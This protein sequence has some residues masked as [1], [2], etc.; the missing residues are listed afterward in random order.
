MEA[1]MISHIILL[2]QSSCFNLSTSP[3]Q[4]K[5][6]LI[7]ALLAQPPQRLLKLIQIIPV[8]STRPT[9]LHDLLRQRLRV[10][11]A[12][13]LRIV[14]QTN[15]HETLDR[16]REARQCGVCSGRDRLEGRAHVLRVVRGGGLGVGLEGCVLDAVAVD[17]PDVEIFFYF[18]DVVGGDAVGCAPDSGWGGGVL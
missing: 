8:L 7:G 11:W 16:V 12:Q 3:R 6:V 18:R 2:L 5:N 13:E 4:I 10:L 14:R 17:L 15:V 9:A 1:S